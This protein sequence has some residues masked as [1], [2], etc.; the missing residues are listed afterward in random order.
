MDRR[1]AGGR[2]DPGSGSSDRL[3]ES[4]DMDARR[5]GRG[6]VLSLEACQGLAAR[7]DGGDGVEG[8]KGSG[9]DFCTGATV[10]VGSL[11]AC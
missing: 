5:R 7:G 4:A 1:E 6:V 8:G 10:P 9:A 2:G 3:G 11:A